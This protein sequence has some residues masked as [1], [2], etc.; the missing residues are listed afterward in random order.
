MRV[1]T[2]DV[3]SLEGALDGLPDRHEGNPGFPWTPELD[4]LLLRYWPTKNQ[5]KV[6]RL[7][8]C[9]SSTARKRYDELTENPTP[10]PIS[11]PSSSPPVTRSSRSGG[12]QRP[13][14]KGRQ[15]TS[16]L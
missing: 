15:R 9:A 10:M 3:A 7:L 5:E 16:R 8:G 4:Q 12:G 1:A 13:K 6:A 2:V 11:F 14:P